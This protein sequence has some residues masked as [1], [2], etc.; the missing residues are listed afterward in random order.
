MTSIAEFNN[1]SI[2]IHGNY[3]KKIDRSMRNQDEKM[4]TINF[5]SMGCQDIAN[6]SL[7]CKNSDLF[8]KFKNRLEEDFPQ[9]KNHN[10][11]FQINTRIIDINKSIAENQIKNNDVINVFFV[12]E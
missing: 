3:N 5:V 11:M 7:I 1:S 9:Y 12:D 10:K 4:M 2:T 6:Y 8:E